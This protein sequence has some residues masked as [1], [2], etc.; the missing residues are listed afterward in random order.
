MPPVLVGVELDEVEVVD[1]EL[2]VVVDVDEQ[3]P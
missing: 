3:L 1:K 2:I